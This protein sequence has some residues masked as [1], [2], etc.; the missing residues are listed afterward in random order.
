MK[1]RPSV[2]SQKRVRFT[3]SPAEGRSAL[4]S[5]WGLF[6]FYFILFESVWRKVWIFLLIFFD[7]F[8]KCVKEGPPRPVPKDF[9]LISH[10]FFFWW[11]AWWGSQ[12]DQLGN[13]R[14]DC[15]CLRLW[16][17]ERQR[18]TQGEGVIGKEG[19]RER[20]WVGERER[21]WAGQGER[22]RGLEREKRER[23]RAREMYTDLGSR[24]SHSQYEKEKE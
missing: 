8:W 14:A 21:G 10:N 9:F 18:G 2:V 19:E 24:V 4:S 12:G 11:P 6:L 17:G 23:E 7:F 16:R 3:L 5:A 13:F 20:G 15:F 22:V 1:P